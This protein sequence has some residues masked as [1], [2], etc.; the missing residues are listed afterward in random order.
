[1]LVYSV[2]FS[3]DGRR[4]ASSGQDQMVKIW[5]ATTG[6][7]VLTIKGHDDEVQCVV[8]SPDGTRLAS[9]SEDGWVKIWDARPWTPT[10]A[11]Q[12]E[13]LAL[14]SY[15]FAKP[16]CKQDV[17]EYLRTSPAITPDAKRIA[18]TLMERYREETNRSATTRPVG[19]SSVSLTLMDSNIA[20][21]F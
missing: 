7:D 19:R 20:L 4:L 3:P 6:Q 2:V 5:D 16:L 18:L 11:T 15:L 9:A 8:F 12:R 21:P 10:G 17:L 1:S 13:A 14:L